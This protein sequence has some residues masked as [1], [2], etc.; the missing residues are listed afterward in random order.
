MSNINY[1]AIQEISRAAAFA[2]ADA[3]ATKNAAESVAATITG[4]QLYDAY[5]RARAELRRAE[6]LAKA[7]RLKAEANALFSE[8]RSTY[9]G[10]STVTGARLRDLDAQAC[11]KRAR[12]EEAVARARALDLPQVR[13][14]RDARRRLREAARLPDSAS[15]RECLLVLGIKP[16]HLE[17]A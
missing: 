14:V 11:A 12:A 17:E 10:S 16:V 4:N 15:V 8:A 5:L 1:S 7:E 3:A 9:E 13:D 2:G 6:L